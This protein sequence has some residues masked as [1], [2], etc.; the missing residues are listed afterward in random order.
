MLFKIERQIE[1]S[2]LLQNQIKRR[3]EVLNEVFDPEVRDIMRD[4]S[5]VGRA[6]VLLNSGGW[7]IYVVPAMLTVLAFG[8]IKTLV[9]EALMFPEGRFADDY[10]AN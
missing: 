10:A 5:H 6:A 1:A 8:K 7:F 9:K 4:I 3:D 2:A